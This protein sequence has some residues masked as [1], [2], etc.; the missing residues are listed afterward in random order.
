MQFWPWAASVCWKG[1]TEG[2]GRTDGEGI[3][4]VSECVSGRGGEA[5]GSTETDFFGNS[6]SD[7]DNFQETVFW[8]KLIEVV[9]A[10]CLTHTV[11]G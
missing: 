6:E 8:P 9:L 11:L 7:N 1:G 3:S 4:Q 10:L 5:E 2:S